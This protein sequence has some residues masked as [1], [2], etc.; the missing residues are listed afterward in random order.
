MEGQVAK[1]RRVR[2]EGTV[3]RSW[4]EADDALRRHGL[5]QL[6]RE[7]F[8]AELHR[9]VTEAKER[10]EREVAPIRTEQEQIERALQAFAEAHREEFGDTKSRRLTFGLLGWRW[11][12]SLRVKDTERT[13][14]ALK[15]RGM[16][17]FIRLKEEVDKERLRECT[18]AVLTAIGVTRKAGNT[19]F[20][21]I[22]REKVA[23]V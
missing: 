1:S 23:E 13:L 15:E 20:F 5:L 4:E 8:E 7:E 19:F 6:Q 11:S 16:Q 10:V 14:G 2:V 3:L 9:S 18:D 17:A 22:D 12:V 21:E